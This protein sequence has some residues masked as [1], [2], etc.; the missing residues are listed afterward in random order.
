MQFIEVH[1]LKYITTISLNNVMLWLHLTCKVVVEVRISVSHWVNCHDYSSF[2][3][4]V[5]LYSFG[6]SS[7]MN[8]G[9]MQQASMKAIATYSWRGSTSTSMRHTVIK[10]SLVLLVSLNSCTEQCIFPSCLQGVN[11]CP[12]PFSLTWSLG[13]WTA[14]EEAVLEHFLG[15][16]TSFMVKLVLQHSITSDYFKTVLLKIKKY[17]LFIS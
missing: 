11:M 2:C 12:E 6:K 8:M 17:V 16:T 13:Q 9:S 14:S 1:G 4:C 3:L 15:Q 7:V 10:I 5:Y